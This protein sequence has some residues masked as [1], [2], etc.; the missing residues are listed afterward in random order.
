MSLCSTGRGGASCGKQAWVM[1]KAAHV[2]WCKLMAVM[3]VVVVV[4][5][6]RMTSF[7]CLQGFLLS[8]TEGF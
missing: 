6:G 8:G 4:A 7:I 1:T 3:V 2:S 5:G